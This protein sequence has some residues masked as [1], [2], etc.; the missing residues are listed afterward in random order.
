M[1]S[2]SGD[3]DLVLIV[4]TKKKKRRLCSNIYIELYIKSFTS[5]ETELK[6]YHGW[7]QAYFWMLVGELVQFHW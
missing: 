7:F 4:L 1:D 6:L 2:C 5:F 3:E